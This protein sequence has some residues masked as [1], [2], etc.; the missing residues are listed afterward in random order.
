MEMYFLPIATFQYAEWRH[1]RLSQVILDALYSLANTEDLLVRNKSDS[2]Q[3]I[4]FCLSIHPAHSDNHL[5]VNDYP[6]QQPLMA[7]E[8]ST[9]RDLSRRG[10]IAQKRALNKGYPPIITSSTYMPMRCGP[11]LTYH[12]RLALTLFPMRNET[13][14]LWGLLR[15]FH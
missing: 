6:E 9:H 8:P 1:L 10:V 14:Y 15:H 4:W 7:H 3:S 5:E 12:K 11:L 13:P 2:H